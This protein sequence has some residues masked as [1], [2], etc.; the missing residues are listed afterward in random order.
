MNQLHEINK[1]NRPLLRKSVN[2]PSIK[3]LIETKA[4]KTASKNCLP[5][6]AF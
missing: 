1:S 5:K 6:Q 3:G 4:T 2:K